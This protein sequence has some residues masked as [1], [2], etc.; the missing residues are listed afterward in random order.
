[1]HILNN[2]PCVPYVMPGGENSGIP[3]QSI[4]WLVGVDAQTWRK[5]YLRSAPNVT[6]CFIGDLNF[7]LECYSLQSSNRTQSTLTYP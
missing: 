5:T 6:T 4:I 2:T 3:S 7:P 1:M